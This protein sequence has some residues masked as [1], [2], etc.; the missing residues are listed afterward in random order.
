MVSF[1]KTRL[2]SFTIKIAG[3]SWLRENL[4]G[5]NQLKF[6]LN[7]WPE[8]SFLFYRYYLEL[9]PLARMFCVKFHEH[10]SH[11]ENKESQTFCIH[12]TISQYSLSW[13]QRIQPETTADNYSCFI[14]FDF[15]ARFTRQQRSGAED[16]CEEQHRSGGVG[17]SSSKIL[18]NST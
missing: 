11:K 4:T 7:L 2:L 16:N 18:T 3:F 5:E 10:H 1:R 8:L 13:T 12:V 14:C 15:P 9:I 6:R 17:E